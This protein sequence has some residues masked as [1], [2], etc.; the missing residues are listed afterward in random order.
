MQS[1]KDCE[2][3]K[4]VQPTWP[5]GGTNEEAAGWE[6]QGSRCVMRLPRG[7]MQDLRG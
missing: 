3:Q 6:K 2:Q 4:T 7:D 1:D 5:R